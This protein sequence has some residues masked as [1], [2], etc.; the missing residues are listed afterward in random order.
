MDSRAGKKLVAALVLCA[1]LGLTAAVYL[2]GDFTVDPRALRERIEA[3]G[4]L[5]PVVF[6][7]VAALRPFLLLPSWPIMTVGGLLF[8]VG[9]GVVFGS[10]GF[11]IGALV[12]FNVARALGRD[13]IA[14]RL[15]GRAE[16]FDVAITRHGAPWMALYTAI[17]V[18]PL[19]PAHFSAGLSG[20]A[21]MSFAGAVIAG[22][23]PRTALFAYFGASVADEDWIRVGLALAAIAITGVAG[24]AL[25]RRLGR[26][27]EDRE[28]SSDSLE[29]GP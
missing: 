8:G 27:E 26:S 1:G 18:T 20:M 23:L 2:S 21:A 15:R 6:I 22:F 16:K 13:V 14:A 19:T 24:L 7:A 3:F 11:S 4:W 9:G 25:T 12:A 10:I 17:P 29:G 28:K 5:A